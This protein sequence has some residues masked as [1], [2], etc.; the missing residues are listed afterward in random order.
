MSE[1]RD[2]EESVKLSALVQEFAEKLGEHFDAVQ[3][4]ASRMTED[5]NN[6][7]ATHCVCKGVGNWYAR[8]GMAMEFIEDDIAQLH[9]VAIRNRE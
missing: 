4:L 7:K 9:A 2:T 8:K 1:P 3:I 6:D 5:A